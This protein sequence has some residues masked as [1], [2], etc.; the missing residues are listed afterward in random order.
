MFRWNEVL[1][2]NNMCPFLP[3][4]SIL[5]KFEHRYFLPSPVISSTTRHTTLVYHDV[6][7]KYFAVVKEMRNKNNTFSNSQLD[8]NPLTTKFYRHVGPLAVTSP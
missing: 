7:D 5:R 1:P 3:K 8:S 6:K 2:S 4:F